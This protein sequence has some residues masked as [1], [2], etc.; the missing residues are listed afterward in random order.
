M[1]LR[2]CFKDK[3][4]HASIIDDAEPKSEKYESERISLEAKITIE[5]IDDVM[6]QFFVYDELL[7]SILHGILPSYNGR[8]GTGPNAVYLR[9]L[10]T[11]S[12]DVKIYVTSKPLYLG[13][14]PL[15]GINWG[16]V[17]GVSSFMLR[18]IEH[19]RAVVAHEIGHAFGRPHH[20]GSSCVM[21]P[22]LTY[23][24]KLE[25]RNRKGTWFCEECDRSIRNLIYKL[26][27]QL[28]G[29]VKLC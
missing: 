29:R 23:D 13:P 21:N 11:Y 12:P 27:V 4:Y 16:F 5:T 1:I 25:F 28:R 26:F 9:K 7:V 6:S 8:Y 10:T 3:K 20:G 22:N 17:M 15:D 18:R 14:E 24:E 2:F 19:L